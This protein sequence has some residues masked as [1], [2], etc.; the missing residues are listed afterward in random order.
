MPGETSRTEAHLIHIL[1]APGV[2]DDLV[3]VPHPVQVDEGTGGII[4]IPDVTGQD[5][6]AGPGGEGRAFQPTGVT[7]QPG[8]VPLAVR[9]RHADDV[10]LHAEFRDF[11]PQVAHGG[12]GFVGRLNRENRHP[13]RG[14]AGGRQGSRGGGSSGEER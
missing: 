14:E 8:D 13:I 12:V 6:V 5:R 1:L 3:A 2:D 7:A 11:Q 10:H 9:L 4:R